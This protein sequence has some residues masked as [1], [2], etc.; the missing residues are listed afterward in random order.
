MLAAMADVSE[1][2]QDAVRLVELLAA[3]SLVTDLARGHPSEEALRACVLATRLAER[4]GRSGQAIADIFYTVLLRHVGC[5]ATSHEFATALG[6]DDVAI[7]RKG[8]MTDA[9]NPKEALSLLLSFGAGAD[10]VTRAR[11]LV[12]AFVQAKHVGHAGIQ[13]SCEVAARMAQRFGLGERVQ[14]ALAQVFERWDGKGL[15]N[16]LAGDAIALPARYAGVAFAAVMF[17]AMHGHDTAVTAVRRWSGRI[18]DP[19]IAA[20]FVRE[21]PELLTTMHAEDPWLAVLQAEPVPSR[22]VGLQQ[23]DEIA[24]GFADFADLKS[25]YLQG[26]ST[27]VGE[28]AEAAAKALGLSEQE[29]GLVRQAALMHDIG[30]AGVPTR[31]WEKPSPLTLGEWEAVRLHPYHTERILAR[32]PALAGSAHVAG[33]HHE[34]LD[35]SGYHRGAPASMLSMPARVLAAADSYQAMTEPR[36]H[37][38]QLSPAAAAAAIDA[39]PLDR[40]AVG[41]VLEAAGQATRR[42]RSPGPLGLTEREIEVL[43]LLARGSSMKQIGDALIS[44][45][46]TVHTHVAHI[47]EKTGVAT[48]AAIALFAMEHGLLHL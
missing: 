10:I 31:I 29:V 3:L 20:A 18:L 15:P 32:S 12:G 41:A 22:T 4:A 11:T 6:G 34:R 46:S 9:A 47:Y 16:G 25:T 45:T 28:L 14:E 13:A 39:A 36:L 43:R 1:R 21:A 27:G 37:R 42:L 30:R 24:R 19:V 5:T 2:P 38:P 8:D 44:S 23:V 17:D 26:H 7:R 40:A 33:A 48:R 35:G